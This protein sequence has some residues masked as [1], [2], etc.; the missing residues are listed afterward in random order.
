MKKK[1][2]SICLLLCFCFQGIAQQKEH[3]NCVYFDIG[4]I[5][6]KID[7][8]SPVIDL[9]FE[10]NIWQ[11]FGIYACYKYYYYNHAVHNESSTNNS[12][13]RYYCDINSNEFFM[14]L[15]YSQEIVSRL[16]LVPNMQFGMG[17]Y[18]FKYDIV[19]VAPNSTIEP[20]YQTE[21]AFMFSLGIR[22]E[23]TFSSILV[24]LSYSYDQPMLKKES[25][26]SGPWIDTEA[27]PNRA[28]NIYHHE[29]KIGIGYK[30]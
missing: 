9:Q 28:F 12:G 5:V 18:H 21:N 17:H 22:S 3:K 8:V 10:R 23:Y 26:V 27:R 14:G 15:S 24:S 6:S 29:I 20:F 13:N 7:G 25:I 11:G 30:F 16:N 2:V 4:S 19:L 1:T